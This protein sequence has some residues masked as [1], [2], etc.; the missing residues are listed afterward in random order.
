M[1]SEPGVEGAKGRKRTGISIGSAEIEMAVTISNMSKKENGDISWML[2]TLPGCLC[3]LCFSPARPP[4]RF[5]LSLSRQKF[6]FFFFSPPL[7]ALHISVPALCPSALLSPPLIIFLP[8]SLACCTQPSGLGGA[9]FPLARYAESCHMRVWT[10]RGWVLMWCWHMQASPLCSGQG[11]RQ[12]GAARSGGERLT[13]GSG[14][15]EGVRLRAGF[16]R[17]V[18]YGGVVSSL[19]AVITIDY[20]NKGLSQEHMLCVHNS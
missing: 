18:G 9:C 8:L 19:T 6:F 5:T 13:E 7:F 10:C 20:E 3:S 11:R 4:H 17:A 2:N 16:N 14:R 1:K 12:G 15:Q